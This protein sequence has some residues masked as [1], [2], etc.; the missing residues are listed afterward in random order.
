MD[1]TDRTYPLLKLHLRFI[2]LI[3][4]GSTDGFD[5]RP[6]FPQLV[7]ICVASLDRKA[8]WE[9]GAPL[10]IELYK[11]IRVDE[12]ARLAS[13]QRTYMDRASRERVALRPTPKF[14]VDDI[15]TLV[16][17]EAGA[18]LPSADFFGPPEDVPETARMPSEYC[19][20]TMKMEIDKGCAG[21]GLT[22]TM[23]VVLDLIAAASTQNER[24]RRVREHREPRDYS[25]IYPVIRQP[26]SPSRKAYV[27]VKLL[28]SGAVSRS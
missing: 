16:V 26:T 22:T 2:H 18:L 19:N 1:L 4:T 6:S 14:F 10:R 7:F 17:H 15:T 3:K 28:Q 13:P 8:P 21:P 27:I 9:E 11:P 20:Y 24:Y 23:G 12:L 5:L 25:S